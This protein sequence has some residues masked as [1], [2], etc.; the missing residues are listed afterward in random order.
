MLRYVREAGATVLADGRGPVLAVVA[1]G[2]LLVSGT[3][4]VVPAL[5][6]QIK[7][8]FAVSN[9]AA[10]F[11][12]TLVWLT[13]AALPDD[14]EG[15]SYG[16]LRTVYLGSGR[17]GPSPSAR[18]PMPTCSTR[19]SCSSGVSLPSFSGCTSS[20]RRARTPD[21]APRLQP[22][23]VG[24]LMSPGFPFRDMSNEAPDREA[25][26]D[27]KNACAGCG[28]ELVEVGPSEE[29]KPGY[30]EFECSRETCGYK[31]LRL[32]GANYYEFADE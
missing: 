22:T 8:T 23:E 26:R 1:L 16:L 14:V 24:R 12:V 21:I 5:L 13:Y 20:S 11:A 10:G 6:P 15:V 9:T 19:R 2:W 28:A 30:G 29:G 25:I 7:T 17:P 3:R 18:S 31:E 4:F 27:A 32:Y